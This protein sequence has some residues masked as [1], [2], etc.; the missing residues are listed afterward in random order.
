MTHSNFLIKYFYRNYSTFSEKWR[1]EENTDRKI[2]RLLRF[3]FVKAHNDG[4]KYFILSLRTLPACA[5]P[6]ADRR[7]CG[8]ILLDDHETSSG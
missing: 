5:C 1:V 6:H 4:K 2:M 7:L 3:Y 8:E